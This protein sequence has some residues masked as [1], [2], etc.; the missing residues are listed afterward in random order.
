VVQ[1]NGVLTDDGVRQAG[2]NH[3]F[4]LLPSISGGLMVKRL[5]PGETIYVP[6]KLVHVQPLQC[7]TDI[8]QVV[9]SSATA[10]AVVGLLAAGS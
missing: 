5:G 10:I 3:Y 8:S 2:K 1:A 6:E 4:P 7:A 9:A